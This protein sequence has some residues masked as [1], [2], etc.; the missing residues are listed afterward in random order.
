MLSVAAGEY[1]TRDGTSVSFYATVPFL[2]EVTQMNRTYLFGI[3]LGIAVLGIA[4]LGND[5][6]SR[7]RLL[8]SGGLRAG[9]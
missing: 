1:G 3:A 9:L 8:R 2:L 6:R 7:G 4:L 5:S